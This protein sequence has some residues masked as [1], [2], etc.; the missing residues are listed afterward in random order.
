MKNT[1]LYFLDD[2]SRDKHFH[3]YVLAGLL[4]AGFNPIVTYF[5][6][7]PDRPSTLRE[8][9]Y[10]ILDLGCS[11]KSYKGFHPS[12]VK[13]IMNALKTYNAIGAHVQRHHPLIY[14]AIAARLIGL[15]A[16]FYTIRSTKLIRTFS[17]R[18]AFK[19][20]S[21]QVTK[22][23]AVSGG[24]KDDFV[25]RTGMPA[26]RV[27]VIHNG[28]D[29]RSFDLGIAKTDA[30]AVFKLPKGKFLFG[31][32]ARFK[33]AKDHAGLIKA[34][35]IIRKETQNVRL[36]LA[37]DGPLE[38]EIVNIVADLGLTQ[39]V[40]FLGKISPQEIPL[41][42]HCLDV[43]V[44]PSWREGMPAAVLEAMAS[45]LPVIATDAEGVTDIFE[46]DL[47][48]G[49]LV[50]RGKPELLAQAMLELYSKPPNELKEMGERAKNRIE[51]A[52]THEIMVRQT[53]DLYNQ[54]LSQFKTATQ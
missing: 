2:P 22:V 43:F 41:M 23:I 33:K 21:G 53:V 11:E 48:F 3:Q 5:W 30:R 15:P 46:S 12:L 37:G 35:S 20:I 54:H 50:P 40:I 42:L 16:L 52:F 32:A 34:F 39:E 36:V 28:I 18:L 14:L 24:V 17:R 25:H 38:N 45:E 27:S 6:T 49:R 19:L 13:K 44:H 31:M 26:G 1:I 10:E 29:A 51:E 4:D 7:A 8:A 47:D 9:G